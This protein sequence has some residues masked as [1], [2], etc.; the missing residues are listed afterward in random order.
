VTV[1]ESGHANYGW[2]DYRDNHLKPEMEALKNVQYR[3]HQDAH[4]SEDR[5]GDLQVH[6]LGDR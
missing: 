3:R 4:R 2:E 6:H 5:L 1:F